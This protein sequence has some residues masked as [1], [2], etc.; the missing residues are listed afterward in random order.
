M[1]NEQVLLQED[2][3]ARERIERNLDTT[4]LVE[5]GAGSGK[6]KSIVDRMIALV[7]TEKAEVRDIA[8][9]TF[10][11]KAASELMG[12][13]RMRLESEL[14]GAEEA[15]PVRALLKKA[16]QQVPES[17]IGTIHAFCGR[18]LRERPIEAKLDPSFQEMDPQE[19]REFRDKC[20]DDYLEK[21]RTNG[22]DSRIDELLEMEINID[23][24]KAAYN[25]AAQYE[26]VAIMI[27]E[28]AIRPDLDIIRYS[29][30]PMVEEA[31]LFIPSVVPEKDWDDLQRTILAAKRYLRSMN[32]AD[33]LNVLAL[34]KL[35]DRALNV[36]QKRWTDK[37]Q[38][39]LFKEQFQDWR[40][41]TLQPFLQRWREYVH[42][43][44]IGFALPAVEFY[45]SRRME[46]GKLNF[47]D[48]LMK[49]TELLRG[50]PE[51]RAYFGRRYSHLF[52]DE[53]Q[54][55]D[56]IQAEMMLLLTGDDPAESNWRKQQPRPGS[57]FIV[58]DPKQSIYRFRR[59]DISTYNFVKKRIEQC[60][61]VLQLT[62]NFRSVKSI[63]DYVNYAFESKFSP[64]GQLSDTQ[65]PYVRMLTTQA[66]P[67]ENAGLHGIYTM[68]VPKQAFDRF[69]DIA[70]FD[71]E[72]A[73]QFVAWACGDK[74]SIQEVV[75]GK[76]TTRPAR[77]G[78]FLIL[79]KRKEYIDLYAELLERYGFPSDTAGSLA[80]FEETKALYQLAM[81]L[82]DPTDR[83]P[84]LAVLRGMLFGI[85]DDALYHY[86]NA[87][88]NI[89]LY[90]S[91]ECAS[92]KSA[93]VDQALDKIRQYAK[94][95]RELPALSAFSKI[96]IDHG[97]IPAA[98]VS[99]SGAIR[100]GTLMKL[101]E[102]L[103]S[104]TEAANE[105]LALTKKLGALMKDA[106]SMEAAS[107]FAGKADTVRI[108]NL[109]KAKGLEAPIVIL[110]CPCGE[111]DHDAQE[112]IDRMVEPPVGYVTISKPKNAYQSEIIAQPAGWNG[113]SEKERE[114]MN[115]EE[116]RLLYVAT[117]RAKQLLIV[118]Q[119]PSRPAIDPWSK[120]AVSLQHQPE[121]DIV[122]VDQVRREKIDAPSDIGS[123]IAE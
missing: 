113:I 25:R 78:D 35:F 9:I 48:L 27:D 86:R 67:R 30:F 54:D 3:K 76:T 34:A 87:G 36:T 24:L 71:A 95:V 7:K 99:E 33:D 68:A 13:F 37:N 94:W 64:P 19:D 28:A 120:L 116:E 111:D 108:M 72:Q 104:D 123:H 32:M 88:G 115:A 89:S 73:A 5:A 47:Q 55:T 60:G 22:E 11:N 51:V 16:I 112:H 100:C 43:K 75:E 82:C 121:L 50:Y 110:A 114:Y 97:L 8:A 91:L 4:F 20:W 53:F 52:V 62:R 84:L 59:A 49:A 66:N 23:D 10:T 85:S 38:A 109:H 1:I 29:L 103:Q 122:V 45:R 119:Y 61:G 107:I 92:D 93:V 40:I 77:P 6:T 56:P 18:L 58:G 41:T 81:V 101:L 46:A 106:E 117:T 2:L 79:L 31:A 98:A 44:L 90:S 21:L 12:R 63:G 39:K 26:D 57:V 17:Y 74:V 83:I 70:R 15:S 96:V 69:D 65:A 80:V 102:V 14:A 118:S 105:W 42:P